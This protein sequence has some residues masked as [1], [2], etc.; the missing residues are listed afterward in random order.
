MS[1]G[2][3]RPIIVDLNAVAPVPCPCG[4]SRRGLMAPDN[5]LCSLHRVSIS[6]TAQAHRHQR[7]T[8]VYYFL[9]GT[10]EI[11]LDG[12]RTPVR[13]GMAVMI[14]PGVV[15]RAVVAPDQEMTILNFVMPPFN[16]EDEILEDPQN[17]RNDP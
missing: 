4:R 10:G 17:G 7:M 1:N 12:Q 15:H 16:P 9:E 5:H 13:P 3:S 11:E 6:A 2:P 14:P 8:E